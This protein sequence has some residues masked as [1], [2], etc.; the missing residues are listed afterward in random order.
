MAGKPAVGISSMLEQEFNGKALEALGV[1][2]HFTLKEL[3]YDMNDALS[4]FRSCIHAHFSDPNLFPLNIFEDLMQKLAM[5][6][7]LATFCSMLPDIADMAVD[8]GQCLSGRIRLSPPR[9]C[10]EVGSCF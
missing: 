2:R 6:D 9:V 5:E 10:S 1:C 4:S 3:F 8:Q 7:G